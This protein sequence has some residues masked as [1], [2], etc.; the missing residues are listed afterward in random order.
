M[1]SS[2]DFG[3]M[4]TGSSTV[5]FGGYV[6]FMESHD[7]ERLCYG[8]AADASSITWGVIG[9]GDDWN[10]DKKMSKDGAFFVVKNVT[11][12]GNDRFKIRKA[13]EWNDAFNYG[14]ANDNFKLTVGKGYKMTNG[15]SSKDMYVPALRHH[16][17][18]LMQVGKWM[19]ATGRYNISVHNLFP[20]VSSRE[21]DN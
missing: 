5:P 12:K 10:N 15:N 21:V 8:A 11:V 16:Y 13:G 1:G 2:G 9:L 18:M 20:D 6:G 14:A 7:E 17:R 19:G 3:G 4:W